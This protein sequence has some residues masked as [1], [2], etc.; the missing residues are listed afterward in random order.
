[1]IASYLSVN[2]LNW[3]LVWLAPGDTQNSEFVCIYVLSQ[4]VSQMVKIDPTSLK[5]LID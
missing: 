2:L 3:N 5:I 4:T 1:M